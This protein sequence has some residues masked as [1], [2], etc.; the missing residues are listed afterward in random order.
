MPE[1]LSAFASTQESQPVQHASER[2]LRGV[3]H[4]TRQP[5]ADHRIR[6][7]GPTVLRRPRDPQLPGTDSESTSP[8]VLH[9]S[10]GPP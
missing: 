7:P 9:P 6:R 10:T 3:D 1:G 5:R 8:R 4:P 2:P